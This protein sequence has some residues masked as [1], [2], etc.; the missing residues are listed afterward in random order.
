MYGTKSAA[1]ALH[2]SGNSAKSIQGNRR[3]GCAYH[4]LIVLE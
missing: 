1:I 2:Y 3:S 4:A